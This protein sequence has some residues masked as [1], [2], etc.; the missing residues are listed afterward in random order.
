MHTYV[1]A[2][3]LASRRSGPQAV[4]LNA[5]NWRNGAGRT[6]LMLASSTGNL[7]AMATLLEHRAGAHIRAL[8]RVTIVGPET[9]LLDPS[10]LPPTLVM[11]CTRARGWEQGRF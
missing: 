4:A 9:L 1:L 11:F 6:A 7:T 10:P 5:I 8:S 2:L 3:R